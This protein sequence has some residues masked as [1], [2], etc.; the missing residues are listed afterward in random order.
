MCH[1]HIETMAHILSP[2]CTRSSGWRSRRTCARLLAVAR[3]TTS[4]PRTSTYGRPSACRQCRWIH[5]TA[6]RCQRIVHQSQVR[7]AVHPILRLVRDHRK[8]H[9]ATTFTCT[10]RAMKV[11]THYNDPLPEYCPRQWRP[12]LSGSCRSYPSDRVHRKTT[13]ATLSPTIHCSLI[14]M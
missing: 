5:A 6:I 14:T 11:T 8:S 9:K 2:A 4:C 10:T 13:L 1:K 3:G 7:R 12:S